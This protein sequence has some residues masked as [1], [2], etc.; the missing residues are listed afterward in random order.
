MF[1][2][3]KDKKVLYSRRMLFLLLAFVLFKHSY[4]LVETEDTVSKIF[5]VHTD[6]LYKNSNDPRAEVLVG[7]VVLSHKGAYLY[8]DSAKYYRRDNSFDAFGDVRMVQGD[9]LSLDSDSLFYDGTDMQAHARGNVKLTHKLTWLETE[10]LDYD[11]VYGVG[12]YINGGTLYNGDNVLYSDWGQYT[13]AINEAFFTD[14]VQLTNPKFTL[15]SDTLYYYTDTEIAR[16]VTPTNINSSDGTF[17]YGVRGEYDT[18]NEKACLLDRSYIIKD[19]RK[20]IADSLN[21]DKNTGIDEA[22]GDVILTDDENLCALKG[23]YC[24]YDERTGHAYATDMAVAMEY[25]SP[26][27]MYVHGDTLKMMTFNLNTDSVYRNLYAYNKVRMFR[28]DV[29][30]VCDS[31]VSLER[32][33]CTYLY[34]QPIIWNESQ[35]IFG[36]EIR[37]YNNDSTIDWVHIINQA[38]T[39]ERLDSVSFNQVASREMF[40]YFKN[41]QIERNEAEGNVYVS[42]FI[43]EDNGNRIGMNYTETTKLKL[44][45]ED[46]KV[47][48]IWMPASSGQVYPA[49][50]IPDDRRYLT[51]FAWF[52]Y[53]RPLNKDD[54]FEW[55]GKDEKNILKTSVKRTVPLQKLDNLNFE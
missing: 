51:N 31:L 36:E 44:Y 28:N 26:D 27:T 13:P 12:M 53:I 50:M 40:C 33:S 6:V 43:D 17:V 55:R 1:I 29:Q 49:L 4:A 42:Y 16:I 32:D 34:G 8:C 10:N 30:A 19:M 11:R 38:M 48:K 35:Q 54:I 22:F 52:D 24:Q 47:V 25:S 23:N 9:T 7:N 37:V 45:M 2:T 5:L 20:I 21:T 41:G 39:I 18:K 15:I 14:N 3:Y 46:K